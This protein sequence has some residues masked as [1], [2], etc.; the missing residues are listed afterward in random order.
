MRLD[1]EPGIDEDGGA[2]GWKVN[3]PH[4]AFDGHGAW[5]LVTT[6][7]R[8]GKE[9][10]MVVVY[11]RFSALDRFFAPCQQYSRT[12]IVSSHHAL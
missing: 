10:P 11:C 1:G 7:R 3:T 5:S 4:A 8:K 12:V 2:M 9:G 6:R